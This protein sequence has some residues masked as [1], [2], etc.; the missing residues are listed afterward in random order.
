[1]NHPISSLSDAELVQ[2]LCRHCP[3]TVVEKAR[4]DF[5][6]NLY[7]YR[8]VLEAVPPGQNRMSLLDIGARLYT[9]SLYVSHLEYASVA[10]AS[11]WQSAFTEEGLLRQIPE[12]ARIRVDHFDAE[13]ATFP[14]D[15]A[16]F[17]TV[18]CSEVLEHLAVDPMHMLAEIN[19]VT[20]PGGLLVISTPNAASFD[21]LTQVL[22]GNHPY[23]WAPYNGSST[24]RHNREYTLRELERVV[25]AA[26][27]DI[28]RSV[29][30]SASALSARQKLLAAWISLP[31]VLRGKAG[32]QLSRMGTTSLV[33]ARRET[34]VRERR[35]GWL[36]YD[37]AI[38]A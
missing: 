29:T 12:H 3:P 24:D 35:P 8:C 30:I 6:A 18:V 27:F 10:I 38:R 37:S 33:V 17:D 21:A 1:M 31:D 26:G 9:A 7:R 19:R 20:K 13:I 5:R 15:R 22:A 34:D 32:L 2:S 14:Y 4:L 23:S 28:Q 36:Y 16:A 11:K 25:H